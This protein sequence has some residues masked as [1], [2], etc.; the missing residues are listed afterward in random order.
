MCICFFLFY[1]FRYQLIWCWCYVRC[2]L[3]I[4]PLIWASSVCW[5][6]FGHP[7]SE[8]MTVFASFLED[9]K[10]KFLIW[11]SYHIAWIEQMPC[12]SLLSI[13]AKAAKYLKHEM[14]IYLWLI[15]HFSTSATFLA[16][17]WNLKIH[18]VFACCLLAVWSTVA[19]DFAFCSKF[20]STTYQPLHFFFQR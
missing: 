14:I 16:R 7:L 15:D 13:D 4:W 3:I 19:F 17:L 8:L 12:C 1:F 11:T 20:M 10:K 5:A 2:L 18:L 9:E 6:G